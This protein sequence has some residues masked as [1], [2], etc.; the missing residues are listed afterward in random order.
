MYV[1]RDGMNAVLARV[2]P[3]VHYGR[4]RTHSGRVLF[5]YERSSAAFLERTG[6]RRMRL[7]VHRRGH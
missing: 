4:R 2:T 3:A 7:D 1:Y 6:P 5:V